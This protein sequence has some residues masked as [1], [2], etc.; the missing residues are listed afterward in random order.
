MLQVMDEKR[1]SAYVSILRIFSASIISDV[2]LGLNGFPKKTVKLV[3][4]FAIF[5]E[6]SAM[7][8]KLKLVKY[9]EIG[10]NRE[11]SKFKVFILFFTDFLP[12]LTFLYTDFYPFC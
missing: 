8:N 2:G 9:E 1:A 10:K 7:A 3:V 5:T 6:K 12:T 11:T 4:E